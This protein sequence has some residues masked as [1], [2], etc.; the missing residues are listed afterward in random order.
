MQHRRVYQQY[1]GLETKSRFKIKTK[2]TNICQHHENKVWCLWKKKHL[3]DFYLCLKM[4]L[5][6]PALV[7]KILLSLFSCQTFCLI[8]Q[9]HCLDLLFAYSGLLALTAYNGWQMLFLHEI[10][11][12]TCVSIKS[13]NY[14]YDGCIILF[15]YVYCINSLTS[16]K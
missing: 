2:S 7:N 14:W 6:S 11:D 5:Y 10:Y 3:W 13:V 8:V 16:S 1:F 12:K 15:I 4:C 9:Y